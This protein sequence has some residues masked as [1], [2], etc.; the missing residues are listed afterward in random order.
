MLR[1]L[2]H[3]FACHRCWMA[4]LNIGQAQHCGHCNCCKP[5]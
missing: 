2:L 5:K 1:H 4:M 3:A